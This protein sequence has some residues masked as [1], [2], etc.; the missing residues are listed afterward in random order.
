MDPLKHIH[1]PLKRFTDPR[2]ITRGLAVSQPFGQKRPVGIFHGAD[3]IVFNKT[4]HTFILS[5][6]KYISGSRKTCNAL[7]QRSTVCDLQ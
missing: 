2:L 6:Q 7:D 3:L 4:S 1:G 5:K